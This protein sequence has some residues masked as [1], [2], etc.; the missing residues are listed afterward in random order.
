VHVVRIASADA[1]VE[2]LASVLRLL[3]D[4]F[5]GEFTG[6][7]WS[8]T[9]GG[10][11]LLAVDGEEVFAHAAVVARDLDVGDRRFRAGYLE[12]V[13]TAP[14]RQGS[15]LGTAV[16]AE[17][18]LVVRQSFELGALSTSA[19][20]FYER[21]GWER[22]QGPT[23]VRDGETRRR[24]PDEDGGIM[25]LRFGASTGVDLDASIT[26]AARPGDDW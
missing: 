7:D 2:L 12:G 10:T 5:A 9:V 13:A 17:A 4:A 24:T 1:P 11:H 8:H 20:H 15:G 16:T 18:A 14:S 25:V 3:D 6:D 23:F 22:W 21:L 26:C 19:H